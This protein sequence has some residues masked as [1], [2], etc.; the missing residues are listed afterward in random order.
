MSDIDYLEDIMKIVRWNPN[1]N[2]MR[3]FNEFDRFLDRQVNWPNWQNTNY[4]GFAVDVVE[5]EDGFV[6]KASLPGINPEDVAITFEENVLTIKG[7]TIEEEEKEEENYHI[8]ER[9]SGSFGRS[10][11]FPVDV[12]AEAVE[13]TYTSGVLTIDVPKVEE[14]KPKRV[15]VK[16]S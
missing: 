14:V 2:R 13:A 4:F 12:N 15:E 8:R 7:E 3:Y 9:R 1:V 11:R 6:V 10:I 16:V 5:N